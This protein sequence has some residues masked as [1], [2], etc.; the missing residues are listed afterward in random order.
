M[1]T[2]LAKAQTL[3]ELKKQQLTINLSL[4]SRDRNAHVEG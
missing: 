3:G 1:A 2:A 4:Y